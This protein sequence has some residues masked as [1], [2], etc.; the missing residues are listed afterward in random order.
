[1]GLSYNTN[2][3]AISPVTL[4]S[5]ETVAVNWRAARGCD[6][7]SFTH[8]PT[9]GQRITL[10]QLIY[11]ISAGSLCCCL[12]A[13]LLRSHGAYCHVGSSIVSLSIVYLLFGILC[14]HYVVRPI[15]I[16]AVHTNI[17]VNVPKLV[18][19]NGKQSGKF[20]SAEDGC[21]LKCMQKS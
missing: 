17:D 4:H 6:D 7:V 2:Q 10:N 5:R 13:C 1:M 8:D 14:T 11:E 16:V 20:S 18:R 12:I 21:K 19:I 15:Q 3:S 9:P